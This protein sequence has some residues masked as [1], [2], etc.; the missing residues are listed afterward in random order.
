MLKQVGLILHIGRNG[1]SPRLRQC[2]FPASGLKNEDANTRTLQISGV[3]VPFTL[4]FIPLGSILIDN[5]KDDNEIE[6]RIRSAQGS[7]QSIRK[8]FV[9]A[10]GIKN[11]HKKTAYKGTLLYVCE[12]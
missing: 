5:L 8:Q 3:T 11:A 12:P 9:S 7:F 4:K 2:T 1:L 10:R 6:E